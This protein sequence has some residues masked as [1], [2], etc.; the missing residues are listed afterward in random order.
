MR[1]ERRNFQRFC[2]RDPAFAAFKPEPVKLAPIIDIS[3]GGLGI[4][5]SGGMQ[6]LNASSRLEIF[7]DDCSFYLEDL[8]HKFLPE[9]RNLHWDA[10]TSLQNRFYGVKFIDLSPSQ[11]IQLKQFIRRHTMGGMTPKFIRKFNRQL[12]YIIGKQNSG[13][14]CQNLWLRRP[15]A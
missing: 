12:H 2:V 13:D 11:E 4:S 14:T 3:L 1:V 7:L 6:K 8:S 5:V 9:F 10:A 15:S